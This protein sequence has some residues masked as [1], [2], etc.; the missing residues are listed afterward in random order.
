[1]I[2]V[3]NDD[4]DMIVGSLETAAIRNGVL[5]DSSGQAWISDL[6]A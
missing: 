2:P 4:K 6:V 3:T 5:R 1:M